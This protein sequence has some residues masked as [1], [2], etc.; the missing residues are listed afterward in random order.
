MAETVAEAVVAVEGPPCQCDAGGDGQGAAIQSEV[1][2]GEEKAVVAFEEMDWS[3]AAEIAA[4]ATV[5]AIAPG[6]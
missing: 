5:A 6:C 2:C 4:V 3:G 1:R